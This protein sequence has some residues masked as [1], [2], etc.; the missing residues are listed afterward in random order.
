MGESKELR[1]GDNTSHLVDL[2]GYG[3][4]RYLS[5][6]GDVANVPVFSFTAG[7]FSTKV[8]ALRSFPSGGL[9]QQ[10]G[11]KALAIARIAW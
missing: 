10:G 1:H 2:A 7:T 8:Y 4:G 6:F 9:G 5:S 3:C 11:G